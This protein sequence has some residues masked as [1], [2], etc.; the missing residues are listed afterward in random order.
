MNATRKRRILTW[1]ERCEKHPA[2]KSGMVTEAM[3]RARMMEEIEELR[4]ALADRFTPQHKWVGLTQQERSKAI[5]HIPTGSGCC[6]AVARAIE[7][8]LKEKNA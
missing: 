7:S 3:I 8:K 4:A 2:H 5:T 1:Q 6:F